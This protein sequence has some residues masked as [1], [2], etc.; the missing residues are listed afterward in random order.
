MKEKNKDKGVIIRLKNDTPQTEIKTY[1]T[2]ILELKQAGNPFPVNLD[3]VWPLVYARKDKAVRVLTSEFIDGEDYITQSV[4][5]QRFP[6]NGESKI[7]GDF[8]TV[9]YFLS[10]PCLEYFIAKRVKAVFEVYRSVFHNVIDAKCDLFGN[11]IN[12]KPNY[13][14]LKKQAFELVVL[15]GKTQKEVACALQIT[16]KTM[17]EWAKQGNWREQR[18]ATEMEEQTT[19][20]TGRLLLA[21]PDICAIEDKGLRMRIINKLV[22][23]GF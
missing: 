8:K 16:E 15:Q 9:K 20:M 14:Q 21:I 11:A 17:S 7:G 6:Q 13:K 2:K 3:E 5:F 22:G 10:V 18:K 4:D 1:F 19:A 12:D 23:E